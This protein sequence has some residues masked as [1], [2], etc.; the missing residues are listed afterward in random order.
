[1]SASFVDQ[2]IFVAGH[3]GMVGTALV[4]KL[5][6]QGCQNLLVRTSTELDLRDQGVTERFFETEK[7]DIVIFAAAR[8]GGIHANQTYP[9]EF[10]YDNLTMAT[11][12]IHSAFR[13]NVKRFLFLGSTCIY[14]RMAA[15]PI[16]ENSLLSS[17][18]EETNEAY[19]LAKIAGLKMCQ[20][21]RQQYGVLF[22]SVMPTNL[23]GPGDNYHPENSH[24]LPGLL[25]RFHE[26]LETGQN[27]VAIWGTG[28]PKRE[29]LHVDD[30]ADACCFL[31]NHPDPPD[32]VN[33][34]S[35][36]EVS[37]QQLAEAIAQVV[38]YTGTIT[39]DLSKPDGTPRKLC[40]TALINSLGWKSKTGLQVG[41]ATTYQSFL[42]ESNNQIN[43]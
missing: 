39:N 11:H 18:L 5:T 42:R 33:V 31:L 17:E 20:F 21:Y 27:E 7:P 3:R 29:F 15:Q 2:K 14:P 32:W 40:D 4:R 28:S 23:Y 34:G 36:E 1:M 24:V 12:A 9:A 30:L 10:I 26:A 19:A 22:H 37:I 41:L 43:Y 25:R 16:P 8:V 38:G 13:V 6:D 35:G